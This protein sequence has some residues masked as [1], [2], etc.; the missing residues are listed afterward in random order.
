MNR[1][2]A[3][4]VSALLIVGATAARAQAV[5]GTETG[6]A[7]VYADSLNGH[8]TASG[9]NYDK[10]KL[11]AAH[12]TLPFGTLIKVTNQTNGKSVIVRVNDRGPAQVDRI[13]DLS[14]AAAAR[15]GLRRHGTQA[16]TVEIVD[17]GGG[18]QTKKPAP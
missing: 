18:G 2:C 17:G 4:A 8:R 9:Q 5:G 1:T 11:T 6:L 14:S 7:V 13:V 12:K 10:T 16:V 3:A 15:L